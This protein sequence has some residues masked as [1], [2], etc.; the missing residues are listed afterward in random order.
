MAPLQR[1]MPEK[2][3]CYKALLFD[4]RYRRAPNMSR[5]NKYSSSSEEDYCVA[6]LTKRVKFTQKEI[7]SVTLQDVVLRD[8]Q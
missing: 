5:N 3:N 2:M 6:W 4:K 1:N 7:R 8:Q